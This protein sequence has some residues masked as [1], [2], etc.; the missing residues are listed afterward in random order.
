MNDFESFLNDF[1]ELSNPGVLKNRFVEDA[2][3]KKD[4]YDADM[5]M[6]GYNLIHLKFRD[7]KDGKIVETT[8]NYDKSLHSQAAYYF[9]N[10]STRITSEI[11][12]IAQLNK[13]LNMLRT[14][15]TEIKAHPDFYNNYSFYVSAIYKLGRKLKEIQKIFDSPISAKI[16][17]TEQTGDKTAKAVEL[18]EYLTIIE[19]AE[20]HEKAIKKIKER[21]PEFEYPNPRHKLFQYKDD[22]LIVKRA[23]IALEEIG[24]IKWGDDGPN[25]ETIKKVLF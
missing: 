24:N 19:N 2:N 22:K 8:I 4:L 20:D 21:H 18:K 1:L 23:C 16:S 6:E 15:V 11:S 13:Y 9:E 25:W 14:G 7:P 3:H 5:S 12:N 10:P 17:N